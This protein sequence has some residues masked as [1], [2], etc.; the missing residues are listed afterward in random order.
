VAS[1]FGAVNVQAQR[2]DPDSML[3][4]HRALLELRRREPALSHGDW[5]PVDADGS[6]L[7]YLRSHGGTRFLVALNLSAEPASLDFDTSGV[8]ALGTHRARA[9]ARVDG[10]VEL[11]GDEGVVVR[12]D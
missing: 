5:A 1:D 3:A 8:V 7:A 2:S 12:L 4:L 9:G 11:R 10:T 6:V